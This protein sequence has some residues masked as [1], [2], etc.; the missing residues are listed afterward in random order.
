M[1]KIIQYNIYIDISARC[2][3]LSLFE[4]KRRNTLVEG[5]GAEAKFYWYLVS[6]NW[7]AVRV[8]LITQSWL[9]QCVQTVGIVWLPFSKKNRGNFNCCLHSHSCACVF[10]TSSGLDQKYAVALAVL[11]PGYIVGSLSLWRD[12]C[13]YSATNQKRKVAIYQ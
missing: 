7:K 5:T 8:C 4:C 6:I 11:H 12:G 3:M 2:M 13:Y 10:P 9:L 1:Y